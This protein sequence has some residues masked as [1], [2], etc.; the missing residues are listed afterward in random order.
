[1]LT[2]VVVWWAVGGAA[3]FPAVTVV[4]VPLG[5]VDLLENLT[6][7]DFVVDHVGPE[8]FEVYVRDYEWDAFEA[9][10][11]PYTV[12]DT[13]PKPPVWAPDAK[14]LGVYHSYA[15]LTSELHAYAAAHPAICRLFTL[16]QSVQGRELWALKITDNPDDEEDEPEVKY[17][18]TMHGDEPVGTELCLYLIN[19][20]LGDYGTDPRITDLVNETEIWIVPLMNPDGLEA[21]TRFNAQGLDLNREFPA[22]AIDFTATIYDGEPLGTAGRPPEV[23]RVMEWSAAQ[24]FVLAANFHTGAVVVNYPYDD[25][26]LP[27]GIYAATPD[28]DL[29]IDA[30]LR[31]SKYNAPMYASSTFPQGIVN[32]CAWY[33][34]TGGMQDWTYRYLGGNEVT[35]ELADPKRPHESLLP[36]YWA[37]NEESM[38]SYLE[39]VHRGIRGVVTD[40]LTG[41]PVHA[42][43]TVQGNPQRVYTDPDVGDYHRMLLPGT[44]GLV[45]MAPGYFPEAVGGI[46]VSAGPAMRVDVAM[47]PL[48]S[49]PLSHRG[50]WAL[51]A[52]VLVGA[53]YSARAAATNCRNHET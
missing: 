34:I 21:G 49:L 37:D 18:S 44:Y 52:I 46:A 38:L 22:Y 53:G 30:S 9:L 43:I 5:D 20:L 45:V 29:F 41:A 16:G 51:C 10:N 36:N 50:S 13:Q 4:H 1:V 17:I 19:R 2:W 3:A 48:A 31:Y 35:I 15:A 14:G 11:L 8:G 32:G 24:R 42:S 23:A 7:Q 27:S 12:I 39:S 33:R 28:D 47:A 6:Q 25:D 40:A 26:G